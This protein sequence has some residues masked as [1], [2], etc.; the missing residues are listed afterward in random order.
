MPGF[1]RSADV[2]ATSVGDFYVQPKERE[3]LLERIK[4]VG[5]AVSA[6]FQLRRRDGRIIWVLANV[7]RG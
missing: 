7:I 3:Q 4:A 5:T 1:E 2:L 6:E